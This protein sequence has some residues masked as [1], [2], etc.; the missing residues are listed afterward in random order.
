MEW[1]DRVRDDGIKDGEGWDKDGLRWGWDG[2][3]CGLGLGWDPG[4]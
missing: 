3:E 1:R 2:V 4:M